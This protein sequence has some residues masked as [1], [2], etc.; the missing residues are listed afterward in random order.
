M[1]TKDFSKMMKRIQT[2]E[3]GRVPSKEAKNWSIEGEK[4][5]IYEKGSIKRPRNTFEME[6]VNG[7]K[8][9]VELGKGEN[10]EGKKRVAPVK[11]VTRC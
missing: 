8:R 1:R 11:K 6:G 9:L 7:T 10:H 4:K 3:E 5:R 2:L